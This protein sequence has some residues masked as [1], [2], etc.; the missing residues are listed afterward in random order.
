MDLKLIHEIKTNNQEDLKLILGVKIILTVLKL[1]LEIKIHQMD[2][3]SILGI[4]KYQRNNNVENILEFA[5]PIFY[6]KH[7]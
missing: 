5:W 4:K 1:I 7:F 6:F 3:K 2:I